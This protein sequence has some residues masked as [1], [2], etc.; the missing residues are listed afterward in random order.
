V[1]S[2]ERPHFSQRT[3]EMGHPR[4]VGYAALAGMQ[5]DGRPGELRHGHGFGGVGRAATYNDLINAFWY[6]DRDHGIG[7]RGERDGI[8]HVERPLRDSFRDLAAVGRDLLP[9][10]VVAGVSG[11][12]VAD[13]RSDRDWQVLWFWLRLWFRLRFC[14][15]FSLRFWFSFW[16]GSCL[17]SCLGF[18]FGSCLG[19]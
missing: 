4:L 11:D 16:F 2:K 3:R 6:H 8:R 9:K 15:W 1:D 14:L 19:F 10:H 5:W 7:Y 17:G 12:V 18:W 13:Q